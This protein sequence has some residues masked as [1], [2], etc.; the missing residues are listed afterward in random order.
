[1]ASL[2]VIQL[3]KQGFK[4][5]RAFLRIEYSMLYKNYV[6]R[7]LDILFAVIG[8]IVSA[9]PMVVI[10]LTIKGTSKGPVLFRQERYGLDSKP[11]IMYKFRSMAYGAPVVANQDFSNMENYMTGVG[12]FLRK[13]SLDELPQLWN[14]LKGDMSFVGPRPLADTDYEVINLRQENG[15]DSVRPG[16]TGLAQVNGRNK[17]TNVMKA[18]YDSEYA[19]KLSFFLEVKIVWLT[20]RAVFLREGINYTDDSESVNEK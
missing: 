13:T 15:G 9:V 6:K 17:V 3:S 18:Q 1:M 12:A 16:I 10:A 14:V 2:Y 8:L 19:K 7:S 11:F 20:F 5:P 4:L